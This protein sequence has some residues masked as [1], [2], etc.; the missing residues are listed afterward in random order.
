MPRRHPL[1]RAIALVALAPALLAITSAAPAHALT[2]TGPHPPSPAYLPPVEAPIADGFR[3]PAT[4]FGP[5]NWGIDYA[6]APTMPVRSAAAGTVVFAGQV[7]GV[8][9]VVVLHPDGLRTTYS[10]LDA[11]TVHRGDRVEQ[12]AVVGVSGSSLHFGVRVGDTYLDPAEVFARPRGRAR[13]VPDDGRGLPPEAAERGVLERLTGV[14]TAVVQTQAHAADWLRDTAAAAPGRVADAAQSAVDALDDPQ[15]VALVVYLAS[16][17]EPEPLRQMGASVALAEWARAR[18][19]CRPSSSPAPGPVQER[20]LAVLVAGLGSSSGHA[21]ILDVPTAAL[22]YRPDDTVQFSYRGGTTRDTPYGPVDTQVDL[23]LSGG[24][25][26]ALLLRLAREHPGVPI[27]VFAHSQGG[28]VTR[29]ALTTAIPAVDH[30]VLLGSP[31]GG[32]DVAAVVAG[33]KSKPRALPILPAVHAAR[34]LGLDILRPSDGQLRP[35]SPVLADLPER[36]P[37]AKVTSIGADTDWVVP[38]LR[39]WL[40][41]A[42]NVVV[43][44]PGVNAHAVLPGSAAARTEVALAVHDLP[45]TCDSMFAAV[46]KLAAET[47]VS[48]GEG[49]A[50]NLVGR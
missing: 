24:R 42:H 16:V 11:I 17:T 47:A 46:R 15:F 41:G 31:N 13:L 27:D 36:I 22:G 26:R 43:S 33:L 40:D 18:G 48:G 39:T 35:R 19:G 23:R 3:P 21:S 49:L 12:G 8:L 25:L 9:H 32:A 50:K 37:G 4:T 38:A 44:V 5:G 14:L 30:V 29:V 10:L 2:S 20:R 1:R 28:L 7:G 45:P 34:P 6:T